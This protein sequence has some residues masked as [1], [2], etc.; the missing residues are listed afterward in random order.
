MRVVLVNQSGE[1]YLSQRPEGT[2]EDICVCEHDKGQIVALR[3]NLRALEVLTI[4]NTKMDHM[5]KVM[6]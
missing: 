1:C 6:H 4:Q 3:N 2:P 5:F